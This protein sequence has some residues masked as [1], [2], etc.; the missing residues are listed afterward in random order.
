MSNESDID[1]RSNLI[2]LLYNLDQINSAMLAAS[3]LHATV[4]AGWITD[5]DSWFS[6][7]S[8]I[9][10][11]RAEALF[12][13]VFC[14]PLFPSV[15]ILGLELSCFSCALSYDRHDAPAIR[16]SSQPFR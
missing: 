7:K 2:G 10:V 11:K 9:A 13:R 4:T 5:H 1:T 16:Q 15:Q 14:N 8:S 6:L 3:G 12:R